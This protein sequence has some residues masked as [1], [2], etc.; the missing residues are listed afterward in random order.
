[1]DPA[2]LRSELGILKGGAR[3]QPRRARQPRNP[4]IRIRDTERHLLLGRHGSGRHP[5]TLRSEL[6]ILKVP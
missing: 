4:S 5:A 6:G 3:R 2:T 1:M